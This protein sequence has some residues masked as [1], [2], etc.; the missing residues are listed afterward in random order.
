METRKHKRGWFYLSISRFALTTSVFTCA[1]LFKSAD[2]ALGRFSGLTLFLNLCIFLK[3]CLFIFERKS[4]IRQ[5]SAEGVG[6]R[7]SEAGP[8]LTAETDVELKLTKSLR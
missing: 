8:A 2:C 1:W 3:K 7:G 4:D 6:D 5:G